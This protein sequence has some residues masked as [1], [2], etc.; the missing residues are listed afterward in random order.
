MGALK[1]AMPIF[2]CKASYFTSPSGL[3]MALYE[4]LVDGMK[5]RV[6]EHEL[7]LLYQGVDPADLDLVEITDEDEESES[8]E[9]AEARK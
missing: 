1:Y 6:D 4:V 2:R 5:F 9:R 8:Y 3:P 7:D